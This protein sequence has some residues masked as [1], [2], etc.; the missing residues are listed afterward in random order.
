LAA[1]RNITLDVYT[2]THGIIKM[3]NS[4]GIA[5]DVYLDMVNKQIPV[6]KLFYKILIDT[7]GSAGIAI[8]CAN[9]VHISIDNIRRDYIICDDVSD[10]IKY[11]KWR[12]KEIR[13]GYCYACRVDEF[14]KKVPHI[15]EIYISKLLL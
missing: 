14:L 1:D 11:I 15:D 12:R 9:N 3:N 4:Q 6:P 8:V 2:G 7:K 13:R 10:E 5:Q